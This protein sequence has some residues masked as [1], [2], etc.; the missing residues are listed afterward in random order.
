MP[1]PG[2]SVKSFRPARSV[3][4]PEGARLY[5]AREPES[6]STE[7]AEDHSAPNRNPAMPQPLD[8]DQDESNRRRNNV[9]VLAVVVILVV[10][11]VWL[12]NKLVAMRT[13]Q[14]CLDSGRTNCEPIVPA[15]KP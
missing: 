3:A 8:D 13:L 14:N 11:G 12:V 15:A 1:G 5:V 10:G 4:Q 7:V 2:G 9:L 6:Q